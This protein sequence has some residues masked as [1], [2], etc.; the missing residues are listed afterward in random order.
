MILWLS[1][2]IKIWIMTLWNVAQSTLYISATIWGTRIGFNGWV[3]EALTESAVSH[4]K[5]EC[6]SAVLWKALPEEFLPFESYGQKQIHKP[7]SPKLIRFPS[8][9]CSSE[10]PPIEH[11]SLNN[12]PRQVFP[13]L[14]TC[15]SDPTEPPGQGLTKAVYQRGWKEALCFQSLS[16][17]VAWITYKLDAFS[18]K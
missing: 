5:T 13:T 6:L 10:S 16:N 18:D 1:F 7:W 12:H 17:S 8:A 11:R 15:F 4:I 9:I 3:T 14:L 2:L